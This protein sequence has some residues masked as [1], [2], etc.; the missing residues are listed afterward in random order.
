MHES[1]SCH[2]TYYTLLTKLNF[3]SGNS[4]CWPG[5]WNVSV[6]LP[7]GGPGKRSWYSDSL[8]AGQFGDQILVGARFFANVQTGPGAHPVLYT[9]GTGSFPGVK[10]LGCGIDH[11]PPYSAEVKERVELYLLPPSE[12]LWP[13]IGWTLLLLYLYRTPWRWPFEGWNM[14]EWPRVN[15]A[16][17]IINVK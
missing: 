6:I 11:P 2:V 16:V 15:E 1:C 17:L 5:C 4:F 14:S 10:R 13:V 9:M 12:P 3:T 7:E 8:Q